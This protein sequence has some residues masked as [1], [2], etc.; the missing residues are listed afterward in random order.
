MSKVLSETNRR[1]RRKKAEI[2]ST[3]STIDENLDPNEPISQYQSTQINRSTE[4]SEIY[5]AIK[6]MLP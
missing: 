3:K 1:G 6:N 5:R 2:I 4:I